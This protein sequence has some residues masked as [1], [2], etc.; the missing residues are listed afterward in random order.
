MDSAKNGDAAEY[1][2]PAAGTEPDDAD[3]DAVAVC[4]YDISIRQR[5]GAVLGRF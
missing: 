2:P 1:R 5:T 4:L 3:N